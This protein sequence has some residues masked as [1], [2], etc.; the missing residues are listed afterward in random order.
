MIVFVLFVIIHDLLL[1][2]YTVF[3]GVFHL[4]NQNWN[5]S[6]KTLAILCSIVFLAFYKKYPLS[7]YGITT[8]QRPNS[9]RLSLV[10]LAVFVLANLLLSFFPPT[11]GRFSLETLAFEL[12]MPGIDEEL[13]FRGIM[14][15]LLSQ[16]LVENITLGRLKLGNPSILI[17]SVLFGLLHALNLNKEFAFSFNTMYFLQTFAFGYIVGWVFVRSRSVLF[18]AIIH[19]AADFV[20]VLVP[21]LL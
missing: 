21:M 12:T 11:K 1:F 20:G 19:N 17:T 2:S 18:P 3:I 5:W 7:T 10:V 9:I 8:R 16:V 4:F 6:G 15:G 14:I 13:A